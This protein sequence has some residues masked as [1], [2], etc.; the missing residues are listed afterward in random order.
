MRR[1]LTAILLSIFFYSCKPGIPKDIIQPVAMEKILF[2]IHLIDGYATTIASVS[3]DS[4]KKVIA[5][6][7]KGIYK[8][9]GVDSALYTQ[10]LN[11][12][13]QHPN[14]LKVIYEHVTN[15]LLKTRD[16]VASVPVDP[17]SIPIDSALAGAMLKALPELSKKI[18]IGEFRPIQ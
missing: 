12:Y 15:Q 2:D 3:M 18:V 9:H 13:Y 5:P 7:Y 11:Y 4:T 17:I 10:S 1:F 14:L 6:Y 16:K 8:K